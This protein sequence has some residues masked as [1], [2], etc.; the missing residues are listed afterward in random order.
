MPAPAKPPSPAELASL[1]HAFAA[2][3]SSEA[4]RPLTEAYLGMKRFME[5]M[6]VCKKGVKAHPTDP[7]PRVLLARVYAAQGKT[8]KALEELQGAL[9]VRADDVAANRMTGL[10]QLEL[11]EKD[12]G[13]AA[14]RRA[15]AAAPDDAETLEAMAK[16]GVA[17]KVALPP[18]P[19]PIAAPA[20]TATPNPAATANA[21]VPPTPTSAAHPTP[22]STAP[23]S[24]SATSTSSAPPVL[25]P[26][27][28]P[29]PP[30]PPAPRAPAAPRNA[31]YAEELA[32]R[33]ATR[34]Y[35]LPQ[36]GGGTAS[37]RR[38]S[39]APVFATVGLGLVLVAV[40]AG[41]AIVGSM[42]RARAVEIDRALKQSREL[43]EK[44][45]YASYKEAAKLCEG[46][47]DR[48]PDALGGHA[49]LAYIDAIR[50]GEHGES[51][52]LRDEAKKH[53]DA[54]A[55][56]GREHSHAL[57]AQAYVDFHSGD[58]RGAIERLKKL[59]QGPEGASALLHGT[60]GVIEMQA[61]D[62]DAAR[63]DLEIAHRTAPGD[64]R[65]TQMLG[66]QW[67]RRGQGF[68]VKANALYDT[69]LTRLA[70][71][72]VPSLLGKAQLLLDA[73]R[74]DEAA[75]RVNKVLEMGQ[76][77]SP[78][79]VALAH[80]LRG[81]VLHAQGKGGEGDREEQQALAL[82]PSNPDILD[83]VGKRKLRGGDAAGAAEA[84]ARAS[85]IDPARVG[86]YVDLANALMARP[87]GAKQAVAALEK[88]NARA[89]NPRI[90]KLLGDAYRA[91]GDL[92][93][94]RAAY[95]KAIE[96]EKRFPEARIALARVWRDRKDWG[97]ALDELDRA[98]KD[99]GEG[100]AGS[101][102]AWDEI[103]D[104]E[105]ARGGPPEAVEKAYTAA[106][107]ADPT[108]CPALFWLGRSRSERK[109]RAYD[110]NLARQMLSDYV[111]LCPRASH[112][113]DAQRIVVGLR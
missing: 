104:V 46:I 26:S 102:A 23:P 108:N 49:Y 75:K 43:I 15:H 97:R 32:E 72:H 40:L 84:F 110:P 61:G 5:A 98:V 12:A 38:R 29:P 3:P 112:V 2:D 67:R 111:R 103:A 11:G 7:A 45:S 14:L 90:Q 107:K 70:P 31:N 17:A 33:Y 39:R 53:L 51:E 13:E 1:E 106:I 52:G 83:L 89:G 99:Y 8:R 56:L 93:R 74:P 21:T 9:A 86:F 64:V 95:E 101:A 73:D 71:D 4:Y 34:E 42:R 69:A 76:T 35:G 59:M 27:A 113:G 28:A 96:A 44:D 22:T 79:Q 36:G 60:A 18:P 10:L 48:D 109:G 80:V 6:V 25:R 94:A 82:D 78:R 37:P 91:D 30:P 65:I 62:L 81:S 87:G 16:W 88:A 58:A 57:A 50:W 105:D 63:D 68:E 55:K 20:P 24:A 85:E 19:P 77:A 41:W 92:D 100:T 54:V 66:E 47:L